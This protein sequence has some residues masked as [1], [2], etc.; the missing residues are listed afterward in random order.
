MP[1]VNSRQPNGR[2]NTFK[3][4]RGDLAAPH[5]ASSSNTLPGAAAADSA[6]LRSDLAADALRRTG[7][8]EEDLQPKPLAAFGRNDGDELAMQ[9]FHDYERRRAHKWKLVREEHSRLLAEAER[10]G[11]AAVVTAAGSA[12]GAQR[13]D[14]LR[15]AQASTMRLMLDRQSRI[16]ERD[17][18][19]EE[20][21]QR[22]EARMDKAKT[23]RDEM[24]TERELRR[25]RLQAF[26]QS[27]E[28]LHEKKME[29]RHASPARA[30]SAPRSA[31]GGVEAVRS[32]NPAAGGGG[33]ARGR[34]PS[35][36]SHTAAVAHTEARREAAWEE[37][38]QALLDR[39]KVKESRSDARR[40]S[41]AAE[42][43]ASGARRRALSQRAS[44]RRELHA[45]ASDSRNY[46][47]L[48][49]RVSEEADGRARRSGAGLARSAS[50][51]RL[52]MED[53]V[54]RRRNADRER[55][56]QAARVRRQAGANRMQVRQEE[57]ARKLEESG[58]ARAGEQAL[59]AAERQREAYEKKERAQLRV[60]SARA[61]E[62]QAK[63]KTKQGIETK[64]ERA[65]RA[66][67]KRAAA[68]RVGHDVLRRREA[69]ADNKE[70]LRR[71]T[72]EKLD[73][74]E[75]SIA[76]K[77]HKCDARRQQSEK[78]SELRFKEREALRRR[79]EQLKCQFAT[80]AG[81]LALVSSAKAVGGPLAS[82]RLPP[83]APPG[84][85]RGGGSAA[86]G[87][88]EAPPRRG[89]GSA[90][91]GGGGVGSGGH[92]DTGATAMASIEALRR[93]QNE[94]LMLLLEEEQAREGEREAL[95]SQTDGSDRERLRKIFEV[96]RANAEDE[97]MGLAARHE[98][99]LAKEMA[100]L[101]M[102]R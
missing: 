73:R 19:A 9:R 63:D 68:A 60:Y 34:P 13:R 11:R 61:V 20:I 78:E 22:L 43:E 18:E 89:A 5:M 42:A 76:Y 31:R 29:L 4:P 40:A 85:A 90:R 101:G 77:D 100:R 33:S 46:A 2:Q 27:M 35:G 65:E 81:A 10:A 88:A 53:E 59:E 102:T 25:A 86:A 84:T 24:A 66:R 99:E 23:N 36:K 26:R 50:T 52:E 57:L 62:E 49:K 64:L 74:M 75:K 80:Q 51:G 95:L 56:E 28:S 48:A 93:N 72:A 94:A 92:A 79:E 38:D 96:E 3:Q 41:E 55:Q 8:L 47:L 17:V 39:L 32:G 21:R 67:A 97:T 44:L 83:R 1:L 45:V 16:L 69:A 15:C 7:V 71:R 54:V 87:W 82:A 91:G 30:S 58:L 12:V 98:L 37:R 6:L 14:R 70:M